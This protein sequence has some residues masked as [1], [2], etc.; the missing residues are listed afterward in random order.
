MQ[1]LQ[2]ISHLKLLRWIPRFK[3]VYD[4]YFAPL[5]DK[6]HYWFGILLLVRGI[7]LVVFAS[8]YS[9]HP[10]INYLLL[11]IMSALLL[12]YANF[13]RLYKARQVQYVENF[14]LINL[15]V[16]G[17]SKVIS[18]DMTNTIA[19]VSIFLTFTGFCGVVI[20]SAVVQIFFKLRNVT[21]D[22]TTIDSIPTRNHISDDDQQWDSISDEDEPLLEVNRSA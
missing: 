12:C 11:L 2:K 9:V 7:L 5:K 20:W 17:G 6:H 13:N 15:I 8:A 14:F 16:I 3:P 10:N 22:E 1:W 18:R 4:A 19:Y 21:V